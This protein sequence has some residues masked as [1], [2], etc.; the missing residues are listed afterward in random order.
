MMGFVLLVGTFFA[1][2]LKMLEIAV[3]IVRSFE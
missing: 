1:L 2:I 3:L